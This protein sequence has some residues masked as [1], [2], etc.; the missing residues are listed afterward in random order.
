MS[1][2]L[3]D[4]E[5]IGGRVNSSSSSSSS[6]ILFTYFSVCHL[7]IYFIYADYQKKKVHD[8]FPIVLSNFIFLFIFYFEFDI[9][10]F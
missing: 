8:F 4:D 7:V 1:A 5:S 6:V 3:G 2:E 9:C 10:C